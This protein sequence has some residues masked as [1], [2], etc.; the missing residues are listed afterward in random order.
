VIL[1]VTRNG[2][3]VSGVG[4]AAWSKDP[5]HDRNR[6]FGPVESDSTGTVTGTV[7]GGSTCELSAWCGN[8]CALAMLEDVTMPAGGRVERTFELHTG[9]LVIELP[10]EI[11]VPDDGAVSVFMKRGPDDYTNLIART[12]HS[13]SLPRGGLSWN[14]HE[15]D[16]GEVAAGEFDAI[17]RVFGF[18]PD[19]T[20]P[21]QSKEVALRPEFTTKLRIEEDHEARIVVP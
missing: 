16:C 14:S 9:T 20:R 5:K 4:L 11:V 2:K 18:E 12:P 21:N 10:A 3:P 17:V 13:T 7:A 19:P 1:H 6:G 15:V 8:K